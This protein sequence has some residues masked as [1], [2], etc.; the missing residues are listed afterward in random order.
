M[1]TKRIVKFTFLA[2]PK[3]SNPQFTRGETRH[4]K[5]RRFNFGFNFAPSLRNGALPVSV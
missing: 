1:E 5:G 3:Y 2:R 4:G